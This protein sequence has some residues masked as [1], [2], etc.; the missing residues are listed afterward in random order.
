MPLMSAT[1]VPDSDLSLVIP[2]IGASLRLA[3]LL[4]RLRSR[5]QVGKVANGRP[6][7]A[8]RDRFVS[9]NTHD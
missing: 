3:E 1:T 6:A 9:A 8:R 7:A 2:A 4:G 5:R